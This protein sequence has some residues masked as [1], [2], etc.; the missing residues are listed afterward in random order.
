MTSGRQPTARE[1]LEFLRQRDLLPTDV[2]QRWDQEIARAKKPLSARWLADRLIELDYLTSILADRLLEELARKAEQVEEPSSA[3]APAAPPKEVSRE[4]GE[5]LGLAPLDVE[6]PVAK[7]PPTASA[8]RKGPEPQVR[9]RSDDEL[10]S[11]IDSAVAPLGEEFAVPL[12]EAPATVL[13]RKRRNVWESPLFLIGGGALILL[14]ILNVALLFAVRRQGADQLFALAE[15]D[16]KAGS[17]TQA[18][19]RFTEFLEK[20]PRHPRVGIARVHR[21][22][23]RLRQAVEGSSDWVG[24]LRVAQ[25]VL[26]E[27]SGEE[28]FRDEARGE[29]IALLPRIAYELARRALTQLDAELITRAEEAL[30]LVSRYIAP[31]DRPG[32]LLAEIEAT[33]AITRHRLAAGGRL[34]E[35]LDQ[36]SQA[37]DNQDVSKAHELRRQLVREYPQLARDPS[38]EDVSRQIAEV[39]RQLVTVRLVETEVAES[40]WPAVAEHIL[41]ACRGQ[42]KDG[43]AAPGQVLCAMDQGV[44]FGIEAGSG[45]VLW[46]RVVGEHL[47]ADQLPAVPLPIQSGS[48]TDFVLVDALRRELLRLDAQSGALRWR[49][50]LEDAPVAQP[51]VG[52]GR[53]WLPLPGGK[54]LELHSE[55]G[56]ARREICFPQKLRVTPAVEEKLGLLFQPAEH[57]TLYVIRL[58]EGTCVQ[59]YYLGHE[60]GAILLPPV[61]LGNYLLVGIH[62]GIK[63][64]DVE[65]FRIED[66]EEGP[67]VPVQTLR[68][69]GRLA[70]PPLV[71]GTRVFL[72]SQEGPAWVYE[73]SVGEAERPFREVAQGNLGPA[74]R[75]LSPGRKLI[76]ARFGLF[77]LAQVWIADYQLSCYDVLPLKASLQ[78]RAIRNEA[79]VSVQPL[80]TVDGILCHIRKVWGLPDLVVSAFHVDHGE[81]LWETRLGVPLVS[82]PIVSPD[83]STLICVTQSGS[84]FRLPLAELPQLAIVDEPYVTLR[85][86]ELREPLQT[87]LALPGGEVVLVL[88]QG[89]QRFPI[90]DPAEPVPRFRWLLLQSPLGGVPAAFGPGLILGTQA[91]QLLWLLPRGGKLLAEPFAFPYPAEGVLRWTNPVILGQEEVV[92]GETSG[93]LMR[94][95]LHSEP[96]PYFR[97]EAEAR[98]TAPLA[99]QL[100]PCGSW[101]SVCDRE[102][103]LVGF[104]LP[105]LKPQIHL[106]LGEVATWGPYGVSEYLLVANSAQLFC[107]DNSGKT[108]WQG[109]LNHGVPV[110][111]PFL[112]NNTVT[113]A[114]ADG[115]LMEVDLSSGQVQWTQQLEAPLATGPVLLDRRWVVG[116]KD[117]CLYLVDQE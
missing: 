21:G 1:F 18:V 8:P 40:D 83:G 20:F 7:R 80:A 84:L 67:L 106:E 66:G 22:L 55:D 72:A 58:P 3:S 37:L 62:S 39:E 111:K 91:G 71:S 113:L 104:S 64:S 105:E 109:A 25:E 14:V 117:G 75:E 17:Y 103:N 61:I 28:T 46:R 87:A 38:V 16:Y 69:P 13:P 57:S 77:Q 78:P 32:P 48:Q 100:T 82:E 41:L 116:G 85:L 42:P 54:L 29:L 81:L 53:I 50:K 89:A 34:R 102:G 99:T 115:W 52:R 97:L 30:A 31:A 107:L 12:A 11:E 4:G 112:I 2:L 15:E 90:Y 19:A 108:L 73:L 35:T 56:K 26:A 93:R 110:G 10:W 6:T 27:I 24:T 98:W 47:T 86:A 76:F 92:V 79:S 5:V 63:Q 59:S 36:I 51:L 94:L 33:L 44:A 60:A 49:V 74:E 96:K 101:V 88:A 65:V 114:T 95:R 43:A 68:L 23:C 70:L 45:K 9:P